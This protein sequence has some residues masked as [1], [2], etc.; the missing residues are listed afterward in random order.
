M[1]EC[2]TARRVLPLSRRR[3]Q[4]PEGFG[5]DLPIA[6]E[7]PPEKQIRQREFNTPLAAAS[8]ALISLLYLAIAGPGNYAYGVR[9]LWAG[10]AIPDLLPPQS[11]E[12]LPG[13]DGIRIGGSVRVSARLSDVETGA[14]VWTED[15]NSGDE[16]VGALAMEIARRVV[17]ALEVTLNEGERQSMGRAS[18]DDARSSVRRP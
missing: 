15:F 1:T 14:D 4:E 11:I 17:E 10:W 18:T 7:R 13:D 5:P 9:H 6:A 16:D 8:V 2:S 12:V 3:G